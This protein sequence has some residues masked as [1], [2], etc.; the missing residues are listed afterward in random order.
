MARPV[1]EGGRYRTTAMLVAVMGLIILCFR[2]DRP[3]SSPDNSQ[4]SYGTKAG[5]GDWPQLGGTALRNNAPLAVNVPTDWDVETG[6]NIKWSAKLG[7][8]TFGSPVVANGNIYV[9]TNN[10]AGYLQRYPSKVDLGV[11]LCF[12]ESDGEFLWQYSSEKL[13]AGRANGQGCCPY[14]VNSQP[15]GPVNDWPRIGIASSAVV[16]GDRLWF[17]SNRGEVVCLDTEG[18]QDGENDGPF[19]SEKPDNP[20]VIWDAQHEADVIWSFDMM[21]QLGVRQHYMATCAPTIR[22]DVLFICTSN[23]VDE[24]D[25]NIPAAKAPSFLAMDKHTGKVLWTDNSPGENI[26]D[27]QWS[28]PAVG[29]F[30]GIPQVLFAGGDGWLYS[31][32]ADRWTDGRPEL[33]WKFDGNLK[34]SIYG[35]PR[36]RG[37]RKPPMTRTGIVAIPVIYDGLVYLS[38]GENPVHSERP[39]QLWCIDPT[40]R[41]DVSPEL[42]VDQNGNVAPHQRFQATAA[43]DGVQT[44]VI[45]N[46]NSAVVWHYDKYDQNGNGKIEFDETM[47]HTIG[48]PAIKNNLLFIADLAGLVHCLDAKTGKPHWS[49]DTLTAC[50]TTPLI[51]GENVYLATDDSGVAIFSLSAD[52]DKSVKKAE[53]G[54]GTFHKPK[55]EMNIEHAVYTMPVVASDVLYIATRNELFAITAGANGPRRYPPNGE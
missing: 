33:L 8:E 13:P 9:G 22:D 18:F 21:K 19:R 35:R 38:M 53:P 36:G 5:R 3:T 11:M 49:C 24:S 7:S 25:V 34:D 17:V 54:S 23:G 16:E 55:H 50:W 4:S 39:G 31:F 20:D 45:P 52:P 14:V 44:S 43:V 15:D 2:S 29:V 48:S 37:N 32:R 42:V 1:R 30:D 12:R 46:S 41:G 40:R 47:H 28:S 26:L 10:A 51:A 27:G 6:K